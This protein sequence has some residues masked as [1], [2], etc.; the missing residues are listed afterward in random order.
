[1]KSLSV[2]ISSGHIPRSLL[3]SGTKRGLSHYKIKDPFSKVQ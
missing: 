1:M 2:L 3:E